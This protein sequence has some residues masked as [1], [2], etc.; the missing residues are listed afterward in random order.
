MLVT[1][2]VLAPAGFLL[3]VLTAAGLASR[4]SRVS[5]AA[6]GLPASPVRSS[7]AGEAAVP[8]ITD[9]PER[10]ERAAFAYDN[11]LKVGEGGTP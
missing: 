10:E 1:V 5:V 7:P 6:G 9:A 2:L 4:R 3:A 8:V 11:G